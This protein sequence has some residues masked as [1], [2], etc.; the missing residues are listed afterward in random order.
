MLLL[1]VASIRLYLWESSG[2]GRGARGRLSWR[3]HIDPR[4]SNL[5][6]REQCSNSP[7]AFA[8]RTSTYVTAKTPVRCDAKFLRSEDAPHE[9]GLEFELGVQTVRMNAESFGDDRDEAAIRPMPTSSWRRCRPSGPCRSREPRPD[10]AAVTRRVLQEMND[11]ADRT[12][13]DQ[14]VR[15]TRMAPKK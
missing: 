15:S 13:D 10:G 8:W 11:K 1:I 14:V 6:I 9:V 12:I 4:T 3:R 5:S 7:I 2:V